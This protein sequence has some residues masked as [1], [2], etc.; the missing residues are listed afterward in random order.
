[1]N[2]TNQLVVTL[3]AYHVFIQNMNQILSSSQ[4]NNNFIELA[5]LNIPTISKQLKCIIKIFKL[6][7]RSSYNNH[8]NNTFIINELMKPIIIILKYYNHVLA[9]NSQVYFNKHDVHNA[10]DFYTFTL[11]MFYEQLYMCIHDIMKNT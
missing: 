2:S 10:I 3:N 6:Y 9:T 7:K 8:L 5:V 4:V 11:H 1:M